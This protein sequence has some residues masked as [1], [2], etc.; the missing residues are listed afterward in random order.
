MFIRFDMIHER[1][2]HRYGRTDGQTPYEDIGRSCIASRDKNGCVL[3]CVRCQFGGQDASDT[4]S[5][6]LL[7]LL[8]LMMMRI[9]IT[10]V[11]LMVISMTMTKLTFL[12]LLSLAGMHSTTSSIKNTHNLLR[13]I[14]RHWEFLGNRRQVVT[15]HIS[16]TKYS[17]DHNCCCI[18]EALSLGQ[19]Q[20]TVLTCSQC[21]QSGHP[22]G[23]LKRSGN[24]KVVREN[25]KNRVSACG[26]L[27]RVVRWTQSKH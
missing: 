17:W 5:C 10:M 4:I 27:Q 20:L 8:L 6:L 19:H 7:L 16:C 3:V 9:I 2:R 12:A 24:L 18:L 21:T 14:F 13:T 22:P 15:F 26:V 25:E 11:I 23:N 1:D